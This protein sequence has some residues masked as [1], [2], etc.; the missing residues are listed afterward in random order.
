MNRKT[1]IWLGSISY[2]VLLVFAL[3]FYK[4]RTM[5][6][7]VAYVLFNLIAENALAI[8]VNRFV[9]MFTQ[10]F[11]LFASKAGLPLN[12]VI[13]IHSAGF[14]IY[15][16][17]IFLVLCLFIKNKKM[18]LGLL[19]FNTLMVTHTFYWTPSE[20][21]QG[22]AFVFVYFALLQKSLEQVP[23][24]PIVLI[25]TGFALV[26]ACFAHPLL[27]IALIFGIAYFS[28]NY[29][30]ER[31][32][33]IIN[34]V[35]I[36][37]LFIIKATIFSNEY[38]SSSMSGLRNFV[39]LF[40]NYFTYSSKQFLLYCFRDYYFVSILLVVLSAFYLIKK[41]YL[42][43]ILMLSFFFGFALLVNIF[44][45]D[46]KEQFY[47]EGQYLVMSLFVILPFIYD[48]LPI[49]RNNSVKT[50][51]VLCVIFVSLFRIYNTHYMYTERL[52]WNRNLLA[53][54]ANLKNPKLIINRD[55]IP[56]DKLLMTWGSSYE[57]WLISTVEQGESRSIIITDK[58]NELDWTMHKRKIF[59]SRWDFKKYS[60]LNPKYLKFNDTINSYQKYRLR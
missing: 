39:T 22:M 32:F 29:T 28:L 24:K 27:N 52:N 13:L 35:A 8:Q 42:K 47:M 58:E 54:T 4:E 31:K 40:P 12:Q 26:T 2:T 20:L 5:F 21:I 34:T 6:L 37:G 19:L 59:L 51:L 7:D 46:V 57:F 3:L 33:L 36:I 41:S 14:I 23:Y 53:E 55:Q 50:G 49:I 1:I 43:L 30:S 38:D 48:F 18:A 10:C 44:F 16:Y 56:I 60:E 15:Y 9:S 45:S 17:T 11:G 25:L